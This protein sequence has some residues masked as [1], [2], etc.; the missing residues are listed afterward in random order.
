MSDNRNAKCW[1]GSGKKYKK[2][3]LEFDEKIESYRIKGYEVPDREIIKTPEEIEGIRRSAAINNGVL[4]L[5]ASKIK[6][7]MS[8]ADIDKLVY[9]FYLI[10][11]FNSFICDVGTKPCLADI[12]SSI[13][14]TIV[15]QVSSTVEGLV[16]TIFVF[17][18]PSIVQSFLSQ[19][20]SA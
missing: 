11:L 18:S 9:L 4:D 17:G 2:C 12:T 1:C 7:G 6:A 13:R 8:T 20:S 19:S 3:H 10:M 14:F 16:I 15:A 5:V